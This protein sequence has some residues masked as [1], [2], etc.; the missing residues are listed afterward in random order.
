MSKVA[1]GARLLLGLMFVVIG[2]D[3]PAAF[4]AHARA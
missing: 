1:L 3:G 4:P 2:L